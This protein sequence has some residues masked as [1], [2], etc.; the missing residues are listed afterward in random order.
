MESHQQYNDLKLSN[1]AFLTQ[2]NLDLL[3]DYNIFTLGQ[4]LGATR[5]LK[6]I[7]LFSEQENSEE[8]IQ[9]FL[10]FIPADLIDKYR[11]YSEEYPTGLI[12]KKNDENESN[13]I[14]E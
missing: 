5:G 11:S 2:E 14:E 10:D 12:K 6:N 3:A 1:L 9:V 4:L 13:H 7:Q 8:I